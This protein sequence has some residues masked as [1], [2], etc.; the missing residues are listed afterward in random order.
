MNKLGQDINFE[1]SETGIQNINRLLKLLK[2]RLGDDDKIQSPNDNVGY[3]YIPIYTTENLLGFL[4][5]SL[6]DLN[7]MPFFTFCTFDDTKYIE[8]FAELYEKD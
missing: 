2:I 1:F 7:Q 6:S 5:L 4:I 3:V 8:F